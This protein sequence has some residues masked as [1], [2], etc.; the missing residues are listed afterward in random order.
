M[1][2]LFQLMGRKT[3]LP[4]QYVKD[5]FEEDPAIRDYYDKLLKIA[6]KPTFHGGQWTL[7]DVEPI[8][9]NDESYR[10]VLA[11]TWKQ[12]NTVSVVLINYSSNAAACRLK[13]K[14]SAVQNNTL[15]EE[16]SGQDMV[17]NDNQLRD[18]PEISFAPFES[19]IFTYTV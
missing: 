17:L 16:F 8:N 14:L 7:L 9:E 3:R 18:G 6:S 11:W 4:I 19:K 12:M 1:I 10:N 2:Y 13:L 5:D 15:H